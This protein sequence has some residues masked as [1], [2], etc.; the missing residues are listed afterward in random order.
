MLRSVIYLI[1][2]IC[3]RYLSDVEVFCPNDA[4]SKAYFPPLP[5]GLIGT[6]GAFSNGIT[7]LCGGARTTYRGC[8]SKSANVCARN[9]ECVTTAGAS[10]IKL[11]FPEGNLLEC[12]LPLSQV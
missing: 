6:A 4:C 5:F 12:V 8:V 7:F 2:L 9:A 3:F 11:F 10:V 1:T